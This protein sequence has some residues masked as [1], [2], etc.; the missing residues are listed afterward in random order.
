MTY[1][2]MKQD[3]IL[4]FLFTIIMARFIKL[5]YSMK[6]K[7]CNLERITQTVTLLKKIFFQTNLIAYVIYSYRLIAEQLVQY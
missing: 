3:D 2:P 6:M 1:S 4:E 5:E 7:F